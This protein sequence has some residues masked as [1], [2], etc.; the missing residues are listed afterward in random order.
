[1]VTFDRI[2]RNI[3]I[4]FTK[5]WNENIFVIAFANLI[6]IYFI[7]AESDVKSGFIVRTFPLA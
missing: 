3:I 5:R 7:F 4:G 1:M 6:K 2:I